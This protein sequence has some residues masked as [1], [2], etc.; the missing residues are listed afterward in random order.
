MDLLV[1]YCCNAATCINNTIGAKKKN[2]VY[3]EGL[4]YCQMGE[5]L[6]IGGK[7]VGGV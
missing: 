7:F 1:F 2:Q 3:F 5:K 4:A 6:G